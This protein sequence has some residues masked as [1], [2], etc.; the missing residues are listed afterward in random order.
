MKKE[1]V[2]YDILKTELELTQ[3]QVD[4]YDTLS[5]TVKT[6]SVTLW[7][8]SVG[9]SFQLHRRDTFLVGAAILVIFW[10]FDAM[11]KT[12]RWNYRTRRDEVAAALADIFK[13]GKIPEGVVSP[14]LPVHELFEGTFKN[15]VRIHVALPFLILIIVSVFL[16]MHGQV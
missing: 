15:F 4:K 10:F 3:K 12:F 1:E 8:A 6:W 7:A 13:T 9:W 5:T 14:Q 16:F 11:N 2:Q